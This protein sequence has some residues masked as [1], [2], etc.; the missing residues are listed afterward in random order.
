M[1]WL[2]TLT[3]C[4]RVSGRSSADVSAAAELTLRALRTQPLE[5]EAQLEGA[6][7]RA[8]YVH[9]LFAR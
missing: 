1:P 9:P 2:A 5:I 4:A 6:D 8:C 3:D 7:P